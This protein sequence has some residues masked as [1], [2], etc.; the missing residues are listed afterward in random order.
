MKCGHILTVFGGPLAKHTVSK[1]PVFIGVLLTPLLKEDSAHACV[2][3]VYPISVLES[4]V[5]GFFTCKQ[6]A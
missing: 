3:T 2:I 5:L 4:F 1:H 6:D